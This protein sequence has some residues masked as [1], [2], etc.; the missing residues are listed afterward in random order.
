[1]SKVILGIVTFLTHVNLGAHTRIRTY[2]GIHS[3]RLSVDVSYYNL[4]MVNMSLAKKG[5]SNI[6]LMG[7]LRCILDNHVKVI[8]YFSRINM[9]ICCLVFCAMMILL[10]LYFFAMM[11]LHFINIV[12]DPIKTNLIRFFVGPFNTQTPC[13]DYKQLF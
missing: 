4:V 9:V 3:H 6:R 5:C 1:M 10:Y 8:I 7:F 2:T 13:Y 12:I 11:I